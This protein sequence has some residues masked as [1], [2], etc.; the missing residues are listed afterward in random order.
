MKFTLTHALLLAAVPLAWTMG[1]AASGSQAAPASSPA[2]A[3]DE[4][5]PE[6][7][8]EIFKLAPGKQEAFIRRI[9]RDDQVSAAGGFPPVQI[10]VHEDGADWDVL[11]YKPIRT[12]KPSAAQQAAMNAKRREL[13]MESG[14]AYF[15]ALRELVASHTDTRTYGPISAGQWLSRLDRWRADHSRPASGQPE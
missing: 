8:F 7:Q 12:T 14:P 11:V 13:G 3:V 5:W 15:I 10:Y 9:A 6:A 1:S 2:V 4:S